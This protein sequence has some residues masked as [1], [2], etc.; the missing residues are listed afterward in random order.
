MWLSNAKLI[1]PDRVIACGSVCVEGEHITKVTQGPVIPTGAHEHY[2]LQG[3]TL[4]PGIIDMHGDMLERELEPRPNARLPI[5]VAAHELDKRLA[6][7]GVT[8]A[9]AAISFSEISIIRQTT[10]RQHEV[11][12]EIVDVLVAEREHLLVDTRIHVRFE[13]TNPHAPPV[14]KDML[15][16]GKVDLVS[17][18]DHTP[19]QGQYRDVEK[20]MQEMERWSRLS[21]DYATVTLDR[22]KQAQARPVAWDVIREVTSIARA[23]G[24]P[25]ASH[26]DD[27]PGKVALMHDVG[28]SLSEFPVTLM[29]AQAAHDA[30]MAVVM[31]APN[32]FRGVSTGGNLSARDAIAAGLVDL[33]AADYHPGLLIHAAYTIVQQG[34]LGLP[35]AMA[36]ISTNAAQALRLADRGAI[37]TGLLA[38]LVVIDERRA[39]PRVRGT[40]RRGAFIFADALMTALAPQSQRSL[41]GGGLRP[42]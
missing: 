41:A 11:A 23:N 25:I 10:L 12:R 42:F 20:C 9:Y 6:A 40:M 14:L 35:G 8:T 29:A 3:L 16:K 37:A 39:R 24:L 7:C 15:R 26:D 19:G 22:V 21:A 2:D 38:D 32:A 4:A 5:D 18:N 1:L 17:L 31:G 34:L 27:T 30:K 13:V 28:V 36:L 33:L